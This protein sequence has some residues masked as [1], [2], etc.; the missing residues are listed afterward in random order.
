MRNIN[1]LLFPGTN[2][3]VETQRNLRQA[4]F[5]S[6]VLRWNDDPARIAASDGLV[7]A[8]GFAYEDR[9]RSG[10]IAAHTAVGKVVQQM[11][12][13]GKPILGICN[14]AQVVVELGLVPA[15]RPNT[16][17]VALGRNRRERDG[18]LLGTGFYQGIRTLKGTGRRT[19]WTTPDA[20]TAVSVAHG[21]GRFVGSSEMMQAII[22]NGQAV[23]H[24]CDADGKI[25]AQY[26]ITPNGSYAGIAAISNPTGNV[27]AMM[28]HPERIAGG[29]AFFASL[30]EFFADPLPDS[31]LPDLL[32]AAPASGSLTA[33]APAAIEFFVRLRITDTTAASLQTALHS[34]LDDDDA[35]VARWQYWAIDCTDSQTVAA[36]ICRSEE[37]W[38]DNK[39]Q[40]FCRIDGQWFEEVDLQL[41]PC[42]A[43]LNDGLL[44]RENDDIVGESATVALA[45][46]HDI[47]AHVGSGVL[48][49][50]SASEDSA[51]I[52][53]TH[54]L[55][56]PV[57]WSLGEW[58]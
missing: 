31:Q 15:F 47:A 50:V 35:T 5:A 1:V 14:G 32:P 23:L 27:V 17:E 54:L 44:A 40:A 25:D 49:E 18:E 33:V 12:A 58:H 4:G 45:K 22:D 26:P 46:Y 30:Q 51:A 3:E 7:I 55:H 2:S 6:E 16:L 28:P 24:Y 53:A 57:N 10:V 34:A 41:Q 11:A 20:L 43:P 38:N 37:L 9:G 13:A 52:A 29:A 19:A 48:W 36:Q 8:G 42:A 21:E 39:E 56:N